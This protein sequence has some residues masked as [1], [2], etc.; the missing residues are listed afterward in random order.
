MSGSRATRRSGRPQALRR[1][2]AA[3]LIALAALL[4]TA[5]SVAAKP[6]HDHKPKPKPKLTLLTLTQEA[7]LE[8]QAIKVEVESKAGTKARVKARFVVDG[9]PDDFVF[10]LGPV[11]KR[12]RDN[13]ATAKLKLSARQREVLDF[14]MKSCRDASLNLKATAATRTGRLRAQLQLPADCAETG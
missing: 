2:R 9:F 8:R 7:A 3:T 10:R 14:A 11:G 1:H 6:D 4:A 5:A 12:L 13:E